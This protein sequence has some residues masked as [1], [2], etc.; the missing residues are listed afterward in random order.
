MAT[1]PK[2]TT[3][4]RLSKER[5][6]EKLVARAATKEAELAGARI[7]MAAVEAAPA[8]VKETRAWEEQRDQVADRIADCEEMIPKL[9]ARANAFRGK[10]LTTKQKQDHDLAIKRQLRTN[11]RENLDRWD[12]EVDDWETNLEVG[13]CTQEEYDQAMSVFKPKIKAAE[14]ALAAIRAEI[15]NEDE[16][17]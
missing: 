15:G 12:N 14:D 5:Q 1:T 6:V 9:H 7:D 3:P 10:P 13:E 17:K 4:Q 16:K 8:E 2:R 11:Y